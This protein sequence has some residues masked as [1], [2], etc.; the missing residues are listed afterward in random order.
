MFA[1]VLTF[2]AGENFMKIIFSS[3]FFL[4]FIIVSNMES[5][6]NRESKLKGKRFKLKSKN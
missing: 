1:A 4:V 3:N 5:R 2:V 6:T